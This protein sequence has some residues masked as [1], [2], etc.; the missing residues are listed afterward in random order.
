MPPVPRKPP[1]PNAGTD[2][3]PDEL[4]RNLEGA[5]EDREAADQRSSAIESQA[6]HDRQLV[7]V[8]ALAMFVLL[9]AMIVL[10]TAVAL[11]VSLA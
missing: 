5:D 8:L 11:T 7:N 6:T 1:F 9:I 2:R 4:E 3:R 10:G